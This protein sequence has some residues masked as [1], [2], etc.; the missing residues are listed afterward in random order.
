MAANIERF[1]V[2]TGAIFA[3]LYEEFPEPTNLSAMNF[4]EQLK[5]GG[6]DFVSVRFFTSTVEWLADHGYLKK[7][8]T[9]GEGLVTNCVLTARTLEL[10]SALPSSLES[11]S[12][13][14]QP[15]LGDQ[16]I[17]ATKDGV[18]EKITELTREF[19]SE[20][21]IFTT[22]VATGLMSN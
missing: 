8:T 2:L 14:E 13:S 9:V 1:N 4:A 16:L 6:S 22:R 11:E 12:K 5:I 15:S 3:K 10:L 21:V 20:A 17:T 18:T 7:G 19:L